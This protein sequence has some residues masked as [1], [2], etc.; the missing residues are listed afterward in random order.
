MTHPGAPNDVYANSDGPLPSVDDPKYAD[1]IAEY[2]RRHPGT[3][4]SEALNF[5]LRGGG[6]VDYVEAQQA[7]RDA[8]ATKALAE[9][10]ASMDFDN[11]DVGWIDQQI[12]S[13]NKYLC[14]DEGDDGIEIRKTA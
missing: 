6:D 8:A 3:S 4:R 2:I 10:L 5:I 14:G 12:D 9:S 13:F 1:A 11:V 7:K